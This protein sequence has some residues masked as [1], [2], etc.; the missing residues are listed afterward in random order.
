MTSKGRNA[1]RLTTSDS[2]ELTKIKTVVF[3]PT[4]VGKTTSL[5]TLPVQGT[6]IAHCERGTVPLRHQSYTV[7]EIENWNNAYNLP[8]A[9]KDPSIV[10]DEDIRKALTGIRVLV[11]DSLTEISDLCM[12]HILTV[13]R[14]PMQKERSDGKRDKPKGVHEEQMTLED[15]GLYGTRMLNFCSA[16]VH[17]PVH[18]IA[19]CLEQQKDAK[20]GGFA[21]RTVD[22]RGRIAPKNCPAYFD[23][24]LNMRAMVDAEGKDIRVLQ[25]FNDGERICKDA[26]GVLEQYEPADWTKLLTK[27]VKP[28]GKATT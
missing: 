9:I 21:M 2:Q 24:V 6:V 25:T 19:I 7:L 3:G 14:P 26:S 10:K 4:G 27:I 18:V 13:T 20:D 23:L 17:L 22:L 16:L 5:R 1:L 8:L 11:I 12:K 15:W 28:P